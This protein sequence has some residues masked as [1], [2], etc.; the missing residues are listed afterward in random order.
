MEVE[1]ISDSSQWNWGVH[2]VGGDVDPGELGFLPP[3]VYFLD[4][5]GMTPGPGMRHYRLRVEL[6]L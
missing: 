5:Y 4:I 1:P 2:T 6:A 3:F